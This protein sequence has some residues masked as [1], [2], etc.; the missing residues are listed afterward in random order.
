MYVS[1]KIYLK[2]SV[3]RIPKVNITIKLEQYPLPNR[4]G[5]T[6]KVDLTALSVLTKCVN[7]MCSRNR[8]IFELISDK[9][10][11]FG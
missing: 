11:Y 4:R 1:K 3:K 5:K 6:D 8:I 9:I 10:K 7:S 2:I